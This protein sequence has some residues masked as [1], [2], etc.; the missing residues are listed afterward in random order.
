MTQPKLHQPLDEVLEYVET[1]RETVTLKSG[2]RFELDAG[3]HVDRLVVRSASGRV[4]L[5]VLIGDDGPLLS[6]E[7]AEIALSARNKLALSAPTIALDAETLQTTC[8]ERTET[9]TG[10][11]HARV[12]GEDRL[13]AAGVA[14]Q[15]NRESVSV[16]AMEHVAIDADHIG[17]ND[18]PCPAPFDWSLAH[19]EM[20]R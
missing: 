5:R 16:R 14:I 17:L 7:S 11:R 18:M 4:L 6:F 8:H 12:S 3:E 9:V 2:R 1:E 20:V 13:E 19:E 15:A 10:D